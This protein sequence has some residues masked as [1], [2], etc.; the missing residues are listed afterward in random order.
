MYHFQNLYSY[1]FPALDWERRHTAWNCSAHYLHLSPNFLLGRRFLGHLMVLAC[2]CTF[3]SYYLARSCSRIHHYYQFLICHRYYYLWMGISQHKST[4]WGLL[5]L[6]M[7]LLLKHYISCIFFNCRCLERAVPPPSPPDSW[8]GRQS[9]SFCTCPLLLLP[10]GQ[11]FGRNEETRAWQHNHVQKVSA[12]HPWG[13]AL[14]LAWYHK[15]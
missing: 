2:T 7:I 3:S 13:P 10:G 4:F 15:T 6:D 9:S 8:Q 14:L 1:A 5:S 11:R 12:N